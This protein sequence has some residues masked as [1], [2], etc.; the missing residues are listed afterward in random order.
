MAVKIFRNM[1]LGRPGLF[2]RDRGTLAELLELP[3]LSAPTVDHSGIAQGASVSHKTE[4][5]PH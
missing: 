4:S 5:G 3:V 1:K 2:S